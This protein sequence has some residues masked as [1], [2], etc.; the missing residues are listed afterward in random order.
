MLRDRT[1]N[2]LARVGV[3]FAFLYP[4]IDALFDPY[5]WLGYFPKFMHGILP[6]MV[7]L[8]SFGVVE[9]LIAL[10]IIS[11]KKIFLPSVVATLM[12]VAIVLFNPQDFQIVFRDVSIAA[13]SAALAVDAWRRNKL[14]GTSEKLNKTS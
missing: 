11:G 8:H 4:P 2:L 12:L 9:M 10:W 3:A 7:L 1:A 5:S 6:D 13:M 14:P